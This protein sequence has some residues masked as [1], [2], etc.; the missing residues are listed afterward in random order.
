M[1]SNIDWLHTISVGSG[2]INTPECE[3]TAAASLA[4]R[5]KRLL[6]GLQWVHI[7]QSTSNGGCKTKLRGLQ[8]FFETFRGHGAIKGLFFSIKTWQWF[9]QKVENITSVLS[10]GRRI[11][12]LDE[13]HLL[14]GTFCLHFSGQA[15]FDPANVAA[16]LHH[17]TAQA[18]HKGE[19]RGWQ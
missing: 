12:S 17:I 3:K 8:S 10:T 18:G 16:T 13:A 6:Y 19:G 11:T 2:E 7:P 4:G 9:L 5:K 14:C 1:Q 15:K